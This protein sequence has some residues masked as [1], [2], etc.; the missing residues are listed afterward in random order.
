MSE[1]IKDQ[2]EQ[3]IRQWLYDERKDINGNPILNL[4]TIKS[5]P[6]LK[7]LVAYD[8]ECNTDRV[9][10]FMLCILQSKELHKLHMEDMQPKTLLEIDPF[11]TR[12]HFQ[13]N[14]YNKIKY[15]N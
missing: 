2:C 6:L 8:R 9:I 4:H 14:N 12:K 1:G 3:Y 7:E 11:F 13:K 10:A 5:I 15:N